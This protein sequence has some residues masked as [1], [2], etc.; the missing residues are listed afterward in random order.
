[1]SMIS[2][3][4]RTCELITREDDDF[5]HIA[6]TIYG[7]RMLNKRRHMQHTVSFQSKRSC[8]DLKCGGSGQTNNE[9]VHRMA[10]WLVNTPSR[11]LHKEHTDVR[12]LKEDAL[13]G[14]F[15]FT[16]YSRGRGNVAQI[17][18]SCHAIAP[19]PLLESAG[20]GGRRAWSRRMMLPPKIMDSAS[21]C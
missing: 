6:V 14:C 8:A 12:S 10:R 20:D 13:A 17:E 1:M 19:E 3:E 7:R 15:L 16:S 11:L 21:L 9:F 4:E 2:R 18:L 5:S